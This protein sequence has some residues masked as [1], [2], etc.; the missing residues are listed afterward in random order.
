MTTHSKS[1]SNQTDLDLLQALFEEENTYPWHPTHP[2]SVAYLTELETE[3]ELS[4]CFTDS[5]IDQRSQTFFSR[6]E[7]LYIATT[8]QQSLLHRFADQV[9]RDLLDRLAEAAAEVGEKMSDCSVSLADGLVAC[10]QDILP[11][12]QA[13]D[14]Y[15][16]ARPFAFSMLG[17]EAE[18]QSTQWAEMSE[19]EQAR[20][21]LAIARYALSEIKSTE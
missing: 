3:F 13:E 6:V 15:V 11:Q 4:D 9:P 20:M 10:V 8:L 2:D 19:V 7:Q 21:S 5:E 1:H 18:I 17:S 16:L 14:L 12:W